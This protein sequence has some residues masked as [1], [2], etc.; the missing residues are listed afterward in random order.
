MANTGEYG[1][2]VTTSL[3]SLA[4]GGAAYNAALSLTDPESGAGLQALIARQISSLEAIQG[5]TVGAVGALAEQIG[6]QI[7]DAAGIVVLGKGDFMIT[8]A[9]SQ[10]P[11]VDTARQAISMAAHQVTQ[12]ANSGAELT[13][14][15]IEK[16][17]NAGDFIRAALAELATV[18]GLAEQLCG[19]ESDSRQEQMRAHL[20]IAGTAMQQ[21]GQQ[22]GI[23]IVVPAS[24]QSR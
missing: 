20:G 24:I 3:E 8:T 17:E 11:Y 4:A 23:E 7:E 5:T 13:R 12:P 22:V 9:N 18:Q 15:I 6:E 21:Y 19:N 2:S 16:T 1:A 14:Q 10:S